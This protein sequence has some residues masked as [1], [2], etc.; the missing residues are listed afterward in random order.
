MEVFA[1]FLEHTDHHI[2]RLL[3]FLKMLGEFDNT[4]IMVHLRQRRQLGRR[5]DRLGE[6]EP[7][8]QQRAR[9]AGREPEAAG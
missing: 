8:L 9:V 4:L 3:D 2:G 1:G 7:V 5:A 6:R